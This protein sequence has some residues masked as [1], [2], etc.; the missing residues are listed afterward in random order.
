MKLLLENGAAPYVNG[1]NYIGYSPFHAVLDDASLELVELLLEQGARVDNACPDKSTYSCGYYGDRTEYDG[2]HR[3][4]I[5]EAVRNPNPEVIRLLLELEADV[6]DEG[7]CNDPPLFS[8]ENAE[9]TGV[10]LR[11]GANTE[12]LNIKGMTPLLSKVE[13][14]TG[15]E[16][17]L[18]ETVETLLAYGAHV[19]ARVYGNYNALHFLAG[20]KPNPAIVELFLDRGVSPYE[21]ANNGETP[22]HIARDNAERDDD[23]PEELLSLFCG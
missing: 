12:A 17:G 10:L 1:C 20:W 5:H 16:Q 23:Y 2:F 8:A 18:L 6:N 11:Y 7:R 19:D 3:S 14:V 4:P 13:Y 22:C 21:R 15:D 9:V